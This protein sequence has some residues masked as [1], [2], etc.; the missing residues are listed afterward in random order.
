MSV[1]VISTDEVGEIISK[2]RV[3]ARR[4]YDL[5]GKPLGIT[6]E[7]GEYEAAR[8]LGLKLTKAR[9][10]GF[11]AIEE[12][13][14]RTLQIKA[15]LVQSGKKLGKQRLSRIGI[16]KPWDAILLVVMDND[17]NVVSIFEADREPVVAAIK[18]P[19]SKARNERHSLSA[20]K[21]ISLAKQVWTPKAAAE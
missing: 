17:F 3:L 21:F 5:T 16:T 18:A 14:G 12:N 10:A 13:T 7:V 20:S 1:E 4:Y 11:D 9:E 2:A 15:R 8:L 19:G 6:G